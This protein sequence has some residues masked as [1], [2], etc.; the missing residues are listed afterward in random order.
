MSNQNNRGGGCL[1][2]FI[3]WIF[4][5]INNRR[6]RKYNKQSRGLEE[7]KSITTDVLFP[8]ESYDEN[9]IVSGG[10]VGLRHMFSEHIIKNCF[11]HGRPMIIL[12]LANGGLE[13]I[14]ARNNWG[15]IANNRSK[16]FDAF[17]YFELQEI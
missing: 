17:T 14:I 1:L 9:I 16:Q 15:V 4:D 13:N 5:I 2:F 10:D 7:F 8:A 3:T 6:I 11:L 12:H